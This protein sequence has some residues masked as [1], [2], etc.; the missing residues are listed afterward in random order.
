[1]VRQ[2]VS[3]FWRIERAAFAAYNPLL[4]FDAF[5][6]PANFS[7]ALYRF[8][9]IYDFLEVE[10][11]ACF[12]VRP[13]HSNMEFIRPIVKSLDDILTSPNLLLIL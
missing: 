9:L 12:D 11:Y 13:N 8:L 5:V 3:P 6:T 2:L 7:D 1:M 10:L 4:K